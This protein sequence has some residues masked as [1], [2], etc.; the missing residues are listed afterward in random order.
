MGSAT[1]HW[2]HLYS[3]ENAHFDADI[4]LQAAVYNIVP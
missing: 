2:Q 4:K 1:L 3:D